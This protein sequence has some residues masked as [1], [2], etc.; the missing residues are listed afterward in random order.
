MRVSRGLLA[1]L[2]CLLAGALPAP[3]GQAQTLELRELA[4]P[5]A[6]IGPDWLLHEQVYE[7]VQ[8]IRM[9]YRD[10]RAVPGGGVLIGVGVAPNEATA[11]QWLLPRE[12]REQRASGRALWWYFPVRVTDDNPW[13][14]APPE[15]GDGPAVTLWT[16]VGDA[17]G[18]GGFAYRVGPVVVEI[19][20]YG[21]P[22]LT[23]PGE[24]VAPRELSPPV[25]SDEW[26]VGE[27]EQLEYW[28]R[29][30]DWEMGWYR[31]IATMQE[32]RL[33]IALA[34]RPLPRPAAP[35]C[36]TDQPLALD[37]RFAELVAQ[38]GDRVGQPQECSRWD[39]GTLDPRQRTTGGELRWSS[40]EG[41][42]AFTD[43]TTTWLLGPDGLVSRPAIGPLLPWEVARAAPRQLAGQGRAVWWGP[44]GHRL[45][46][47]DAHRAITLWDLDTGVQTPLS[48]E[49]W[50]RIDSL[51]WSPDGTRILGTVSMDIVRPG[52][53]LL[54][55]DPLNSGWEPPTY[56]APPDSSAGGSLEPSFGQRWEP[57]HN[58][59]QIWDAT[60]GQGLCT[61]PEG[62][63]T[64][65]WLRVGPAWAE[66][67]SW[68]PSGDRLALRWSD[69]SSSPRQPRVLSVV[70]ALT[71]QETLS[72]LAPPW[73]QVVRWSPDG[74]RLTTRGQDGTRAEWDTTTGMLRV[75][76]DDAPDSERSWSPDR[77]LWATWGEGDCGR[78][79]T[80]EVWEA[81]TGEVVGTL[82]AA[83]EAGWPAWSPTGEWLAVQLGVRQFPSELDQAGPVLRLSSSVL[84]WD[85]RSGQ[86]HELDPCP[87]GELV[88]QEAQPFLSTIMWSPDG[89]QVA[90]SCGA[91]SLYR[92][93]RQEVTTIIM[94]DVA[95]GERRWVLRSLDGGSRS[96]SPDGRYLIESSPYWYP[97]LRVWDLNTGAYGSR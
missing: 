72:V 59:V 77:A 96:W 9:L 20:R 74:A 39:P 42:P 58:F 56:Y 69:P 26:S 11:Q 61:L 16:A 12:R 44:I 95:T 32:A 28:S 91:A 94:W 46:T 85:P 63:T 75:V 86:R 8:G 33:L 83:C 57:P 29:H 25:G 21:G 92:A 78:F 55:R 7:D 79:S 3:P 14:F 49:P 34:G 22:D 82:S 70:D 37:G 87:A 18:I 73:P 53:E 30:S 5:A 52:P 68:S 80:V 60:S 10:Y 17:L 81:R 19:V 93:D 2:L 27:A 51:E 54:Y 4:L 66:G 40:I 76:W 47:E 1:L 62:A 65:N 89:G 84:L 67:T 90:T 15:V 88:S 31:H 38:L 71:C 48:R 64:L 43:D 13:F 23:W 45:A 36:A 50:W 97:N 35:G 6:D 24:P 41:V